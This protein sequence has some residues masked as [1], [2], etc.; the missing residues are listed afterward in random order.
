MHTLDAEAR[1]KLS[2]MKRFLSSSAIIALEWSS[3]SF[4]QAITVL[5][6]KLYV[7]SVHKYQHYTLQS[8][9]TAQMR[10]CC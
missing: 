10:T 2:T 1:Q 6:Y 4:S 8:T 5:N 3:H 7:V 9:A